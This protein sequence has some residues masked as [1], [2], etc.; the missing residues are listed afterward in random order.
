MT[1]RLET[2][3]RHARIEDL[4]PIF[5]AGKVAIVSDELGF[6]GLITRVNVLNALRRRKLAA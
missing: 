5:A 2:V 3:S 1:R 6:H 4:L